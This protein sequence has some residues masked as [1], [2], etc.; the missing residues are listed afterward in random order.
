MGRVNKT[1]E[2][3]YKYY[4]EMWDGEN[5]KWKAEVR[6]YLVEQYAEDY[7]DNANRRNFKSLEYEDRSDD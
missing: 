3:N 2:G 6:S 4:V 1:G 7:P 5:K